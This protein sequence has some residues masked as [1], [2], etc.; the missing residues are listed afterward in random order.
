MAPP[1]LAQQPPITEAGGIRILGPPPPVAPAVES[2]DEEG[3]VTIRAVR[4]TEMNTDGILDEPF[5]QATAS[6][7]GFVQSVPISGAEPTE[8]TEAWI[9]FDDDNVYISARVWYSAPR[10]EWVANSMQ[11]DASSN[12]QQDQFGVFLDTF[13]DRRNSI[14]IYLNPTGGFSDL[15]VTNE[16]S[17]NF[18]WNPVTEV[19]TARFDGGWTLEIAIPFKSIRYRAGREQVWGIR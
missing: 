11:R 16:G 5:Y 8:L 17:P 19:R 13:Y 14:G 1:A 10:S 6:V 18:D 4:V 3:R 9:S 7:S 2:R 12:R 15:Q